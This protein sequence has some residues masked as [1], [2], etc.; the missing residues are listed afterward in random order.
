MV[1][2]KDSQGEL[3]KLR[4][5]LLE[6]EQKKLTEFESQLETLQVD[7]PKVA[8]VLPKA[9]AMR[10]ASNDKHLS[11]A[12]APTIESAIR[13]SI[14]NDPRQFADALSPLMGPAIRKSVFLALH[15]LVSSIGEVLKHSLSFRSLKWRL[16]A[17]RTGRPFAEIVLV[18]S[19]R[20]R[21]EQILLIHRKTGLLLRHESVVSAITYDEDIFAA[22]LTAIQEFI[23]DSISTESGDGID[24][25]QIGGKTIWFEYGQNAVLAGVIWGEAPCE[26]KSLFTETV[27]MMHL[28]LGQELEAGDTMASETY[29]KY[30]RPC[31][32][33]KQY[34][35]CKTRFQF[36]YWF[37]PVLLIVA[38]LVVYVFLNGRMVGHENRQWDNYIQRLEAEPGIVV[39]KSG[40]SDGKFYLSALYDPLAKS[41]SEILGEYRINSSLVDVNLK[42]F[43][44]MD[45]KFTLM[46]A[47]RILAPPEGVVLELKNR[48]LIVSGTAP[49]KW[50]VG[51]RKISADLFD[52]FGYDDSRLVDRDFREIEEVRDRI[53]GQIFYFT[54]ANSIPEAYDEEYEIV[55]QDINALRELV[56]AVGMTVTIEACGSADAVTGTEEINLRLSQNRAEYIVSRL[57]AMG[58][59]LEILSSNGEIFTPS[60]AGMAE[61]SL[62]A[63]RKVS[64]SVTLHRPN[65]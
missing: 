12:L 15:Q 19:L 13:S 33:K 24:S 25:L 45:S 40:E 51:A 5:L 34:E 6:P 20:Y 10:A 53:E 4:H 52:I 21:V 7:A 38:A 47:R 50:V 44:A 58:A 11:M 63:Y 30:L 9:I 1:G 37:V 2:K 60:Y 26:V 42:P 16:E 65:D 54:K 57:T 32:V 14:K 49:H 28:Q 17:F 43:L 48:V 55:V 64:F 59:P 46:R 39:I 35:R 29:G 56:Q 27:E 41:P 3:G 36:L 61:E 62:R 22:M 18:H 31:L 8:A 23:H